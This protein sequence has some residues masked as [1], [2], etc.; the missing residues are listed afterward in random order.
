MRLDLAMPAGASDALTLAQLARPGRLLLGITA[1]P[2]DAQRL[3]EEILWF[4]P[5]LRVH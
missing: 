1:S 3:Q 2:L 4:A 5:A